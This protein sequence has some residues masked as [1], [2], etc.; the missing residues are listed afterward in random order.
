VKPLCGHLTLG[1]P[2]PHSFNSVGILKIQLLSD[3]HLEVEDYHPEPH[4]S[5]DL[6][7]LA[8]D[9]DAR[10]FGLEYFKRWPKPVIFVAG[11]HEFDQRDQ[12]S[13][14][15][16][17]RALCT[18]FGIHMLEK[19]SLVLPQFPEV[20]FIG[21][22]RWCD[23]DLLGTGLRDKAMRAATHYLRT[24]GMTVDGK[25]ILSE[26]VREMGLRSRQWLKAEL[27]LPR[28]EAKTVVITHFAPSGK[29]AD[30][31]Y[32][33]QPGT[34]GFCNADEDLMPGVDL[35]LHGHLHCP[36]AYQIGA[37]RVVANPRGYIRKG[38]TLGFN[39]DLLIDLAEGPS[40]KQ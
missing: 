5:A 8:G 20:R 9:I 36:S 23:F 25:E 32:G 13:A 29:S 35:W 30:P 7:V 34:A 10:W 31:R 14:W 3:L 12:S 33:M 37:C 38:E 26:G 39:P 2:W 28:V 24:A 18:E 40:G 22:T 11:N 4:P 1:E 27:S 19:E 17:L 15:T 6:L 21:C 16:S